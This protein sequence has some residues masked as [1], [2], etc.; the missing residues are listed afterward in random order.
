LK[1]EEIASMGIVATAVTATSHA[2]EAA[3][4]GVVS[5]HET[6][7][8]G[9]AELVTAAAAERQSRAALARTQ[10]L[11]GTAGAMPADAQESAE[12]QET[13]DQAAL[14]LAQQRLT[15]SFGQDPK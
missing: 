2:P 11:V 14:L 15:A 10:R 4:F 12:R 7:A 6:I 3:G 5:P 9:V 13:V 8:Q 1:P